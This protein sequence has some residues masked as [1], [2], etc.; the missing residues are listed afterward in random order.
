[1]QNTQLYNRIMTDLENEGKTLPAVSGTDEGKVLTVNS[2]GEWEAGEASGG[3]QVMH[4]TNVDGVLN[5]TWQEI[6]DAQAAGTIVYEAGGDTEVSGVTIFAG[7]YTDDGSYYVAI[8][9]SDTSTGYVIN[10][11]DGYPVFYD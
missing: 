5:A 1:M 4:L 8:S 9:W 6:H 11:P 2:D 7:T 3:G 10:D